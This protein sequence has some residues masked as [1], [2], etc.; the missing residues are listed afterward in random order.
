[1]GGAF[2]AVANDSSATW[3][4]PAGL[5]AGPFFDMAIARN[6][7][8]QDERL[9]A[10][11]SGAWSFSVGTPPFGLSYYRLRLTE[12]RAA[13]P[14]AQDLANREDRR[15][16]VDVRSLSVSQFGATILHTVLTGVHVGTTVKYVRATPRA[17]FVAAAADIPALLDRGGDLEGGDAEGAFDL[18][19]GVLAVFGGIRVGAVVRHLR[20]PG[21]DLPAAAAD[22]EPMRLPRQV[23]VGAAFDADAAGLLPLTVSLDADVDA[24]ATGSGER[25]VVALGAE[26][27]LLSRRLGVRGGARFN[28]VGARDE[29]VTGGL[30]VSLRPGTYVDAHVVAGGDG[31]EEGWGVAARVSF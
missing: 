22:V 21:F 14:T 31:G 13:D 28:T 30:S 6:A 4:N 26:H 27:W 15:A 3:W 2:V 10:A 23:R 17:A 16:G 29:A 18:D 24:Y 11:R 8:V 5:A 9:P 25:R 20:E 19:V 1:M 12:I 7:G